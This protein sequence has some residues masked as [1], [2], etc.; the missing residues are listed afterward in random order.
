[1]DRQ[2]PAGF[3]F[4][5]GAIGLGLIGAFIALSV[6]IGEDFAIPAMVVGAILSA[7]AL[8]GPVGKALAHWID[9]SAR[10]EVGQLPEENAAEIEDMRIRLVEL[11][12]R[13]DFAERLLTRG[14]DSAPVS[15][16]ED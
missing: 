5:V 8:R 12:E 6:V 14:R 16:R 13:L 3:G 7:I 2:L 15:P 1:M 11:E 4:A 9:G 10:G